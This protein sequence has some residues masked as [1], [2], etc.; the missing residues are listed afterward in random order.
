[1]KWLGKVEEEQITIQVDN[2]E[3]ITQ[4]KMINLT[5][6]EIQVGKCVQALIKQHLEQIVSIFYKTVLDVPELKGIILRNSSIER[7]KRWKVI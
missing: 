6:E 4:M 2:H 5:K 1:M 3:I 7:L